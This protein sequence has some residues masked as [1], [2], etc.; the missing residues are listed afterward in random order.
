VEHC[1][2]KINPIDRLLRRVDYKQENL[3]LTCLLLTLQNKLLLRI[4]Y[5]REGESINKPSLLSA[6]KTYIANI[7]ST[8]KVF[9]TSAIG[10]IPCVLRLLARVLVSSKPAIVEPTLILKIG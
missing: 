9:T 5:S 3:L 6:Y 4:K 8:R 10:C 7:Y 1:L 2:G